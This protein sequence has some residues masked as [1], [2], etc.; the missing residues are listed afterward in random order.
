MSNQF[1]RS[2]FTPTPTP[3]AGY[4]FIILAG[5]GPY[6]DSGAAPGVEVARLS[7]PQLYSTTKALAA[8]HSQHTIAGRRRRGEQ[9]IRECPGQFP[10]FRGWR[11]HVHNV[12]HRNLSRGPGQGHHRRQQQLVSASVVQLT[13][14]R[15]IHR[16]IDDRWRNRRSG[17]SERRLAR[18]RPVALNIPKASKVL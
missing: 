14:E 18:P 16:A 6:T 5:E 17:R 11:R 10:D 15:G 2:R 4:S 9:C 1:R 8:A 13:Q 7:V 3:G 12:G